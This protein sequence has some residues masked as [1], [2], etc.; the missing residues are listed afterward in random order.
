[1]DVCVCIKFKNNLIGSIRKDCPLNHN[2]MKIKFHF[3]GWIIKR[4][5]TTKDF[6][7]FR[8]LL[9]DAMIRVICY[10]RLLL[11]FTKYAIKPWFMS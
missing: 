7:N 1:M 11:I 9:Y 10:N 2:Q 8:V 6:T 4:E 5:S 3:Q